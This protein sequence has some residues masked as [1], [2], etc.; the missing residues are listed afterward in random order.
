MIG[1]SKVNIVL[2]KL[3]YNEAEIHLITWNGSPCFI[4]SEI[5]KALDGANKEDMSLFL[6]HNAISIKGVDYDVI[7]DVEARVLRSNLEESGVVKRFAKA[8]VIYFS[9]MRK[10]FGFRRTIQIKDFSDYLI[11]NKVF[12][13]EDET[14]TKSIS[15]TT[16]TLP[17]SDNPIVETVPTAIQDNNMGFKG[18]S[19]F[20]RHIAFMEEFV[21]SINKLNISPDKSI[22]F[23]MDMAKFLEDNGLQPEKLLAQIKKWI[24]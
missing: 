19:E 7:Q 16:A 2:R 3:I 22:A 5:N 14:H 8:M 11:K 12:I 13:A 10:Y 4:V 9:G 24:V 6:R 21:N 20:Y 1:G 17:D 23:T 18:Y 15:N